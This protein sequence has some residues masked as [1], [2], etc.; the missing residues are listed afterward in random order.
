MDFDLAP[1]ETT[2]LKESVYNKLLNSITSG[3]L[4]PGTQVT[5]AQL[6][7]LVGVSLMPVREALQKLAAGNFISVQ[8]NR[9]IAINQL[10]KRGSERVASDSREVGVHGRE[11]GDKKLDA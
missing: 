9:R 5:I 4:P 3:K 2:T 8:K 7:A 6:S 11:G 1:V 10:S